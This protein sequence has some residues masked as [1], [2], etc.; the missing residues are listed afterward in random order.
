M[1]LITEFNSDI[2]YLKEGVEGQPKK[3]IIEGIFMTAEAKNRNNRVYKKEILERAVNEYVEQQVKTNR[4]V[5]EINHP[6]SPIVNYKEA[7]HKIVSLE[8][9]G[10]DVVG[11][12]EVLNTPNGQIVKALL[13][14]GVQIG[15]SSRG[16]GSVRTVES[17]NYVEP[18]FIL[19]T[20][21]IVQDPSAH[22][23]FVKSVNEKYEWIMENGVFVAHDVKKSQ[24]RDHNNIDNLSETQTLKQ[25]MRFLRS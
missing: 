17:T 4:A 10:N 15:V 2:S 1:K 9:K 8:W 13:D 21:D 24:V 11:R 22:N 18:D 19:A 16:M 14:G 7:S 20:V 5:G 25:L 23:A 3:Y 12:A 6:E